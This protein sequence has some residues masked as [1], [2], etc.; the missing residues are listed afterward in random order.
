MCP[1]L[2][3][4]IGGLFAGGAGAGAATA[5]GAGAA[6][7]GGIGL[8]GILKLVGAG[9]TGFAQL[10]SSRAQAKSLEAQAEFS[11]RQAA[12][13][14]QRG[15][16][17]ADRARD[18][19][20][21]LQGQQVANFA[22]SGVQIDGSAGNIIDD[23]AAEAALEVSSILYGAELRSD[24]EI[25]KSKTARVN[26]ANTRSAAPILAIAPVIKGAS[27]INWGGV[28]AT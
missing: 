2:F 21:R 1:P 22:A 26:A 17:E 13:E 6:A 27:R 4:A 11:E 7:S 24:N 19:A 8:G 18:K 23:S 5:A 10:Q 25:Y 28:Y 12:I 16:F 14:R 15:A 3:A 9:L 20:R